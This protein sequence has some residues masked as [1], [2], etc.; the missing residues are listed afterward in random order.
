MNKNK[1]GVAELSNAVIRIGRVSFLDLSNAEE[2]EEELSLH[3][4]P[5]PPHHIL[6]LSALTSKES[7]PEKISSH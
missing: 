3:P 2:S 7:A 6:I 1:T 4:N 5:Q